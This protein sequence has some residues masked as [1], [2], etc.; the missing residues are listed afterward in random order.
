M[1]GYP[2]ETFLNVKLAPDSFLEKKRRTAS[3]ASLKQQLGFMK[4]TGRYEAFKLKWLPVYDEPPAIWPIGSWLFWDSDIGKWLE[5]ACYFLHTD[6]DAEIDAAVQELTDMLSNAQHDDGYLNLHYSI[7]EPTSNRF[8]NIRDFCELYNAGHLLEGALA[9][10]HYYKNDKLLGPMIRYVDLMIK[11]FGP[12]EDQ[13]HAYPGHPELEIALLRLHER[14][15]DKRHFEL[16]KYFIT[17]RGNPKGVDGRHY[18]DWEA[19]K[20][21]D[22][23]N[24]RPYFYPER[25]PSNWYYSAS[26]PLVDMQTVE[27]HSVRPMYLL[28]A[29]A[30]MVRIDKANT[31][32]LRKAIVRLWEDMVSTKMYVTGGIGAMPQYEGF[33]IPYFLPQGTDEG[34][35]YAETCAAIGIMMMVERVLQYDLDGSF[36]DILELAF[37]NAVLTA[38][39]TDGR[40]YTYVN[41][42]ASSDANPAERSDTLDFTVSDHP[43]SLT[44]STDWPWSGNVEFKLETSS[45]AVRI[46]LRI[47]QWTSEWSIEPPPPYKE[48]TKGYI[49]LPAEYLASNPNFTLKIK[50]ETRILASHPF[51]NT[52]TIAVARGPIIYC[53][54]DFDNPWVD[55]HFKSLQLDPDAVVTERA[56]KDPST[57]EEYVALDVHRGASLLPIKSLKAAPSIPWKTLS[58]AAAD[59]EVIELLHMVPYYFRSNRGGRGMARTGIRRW[60]R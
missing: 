25:T 20:R 14:T 47:P 58:K 41:Q 60:I 32:D 15:H 11:T 6:Y 24:A 50:L 49:T 51:V 48:V 33:G 26:V 52:D 28:T 8:T 7:V 29:V 16:A 22:D 4:S 17:E 3:V 21:G 35:C 45:K 40:K 18:Y 38:S 56:V 31:S 37:Y 1:A 46:S 36:T 5:G 43:S 27:G 53:V 9:H 57:G 44:Q 12:G 59:A 34:G 54:E 2:Q 23:P 55:D 13:L 30:D 19:D 10:E 42:L 39:S